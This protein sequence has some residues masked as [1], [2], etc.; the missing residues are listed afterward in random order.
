MIMTIPNPSCRK[1]LASA[2]AEVL[3]PAQMTAA[4]EM[5]LAEAPGRPSPTP[6]EILY[7]MRVNMPMATRRVEEILHPN[8]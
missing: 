1:S 8:G 7:W 5:I 4:R 2:I 3:S 6:K